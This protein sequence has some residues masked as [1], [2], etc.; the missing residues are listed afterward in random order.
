MRSVRTEG[1]L[2]KSKK[3][4]VLMRSLKEGFKMT[5]I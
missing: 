4:I 5:Y 3:M 2:S 1:E